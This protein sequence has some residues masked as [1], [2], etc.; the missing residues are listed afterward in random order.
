[1]IIAASGCLADQR[2]AKLLVVKL[3][4]SIAQSQEHSASASPSK[5]PS[6]SKQ[7]ECASAT[8]TEWPIGHVTGA[9][10]NLQPTTQ[11]VAE[12]VSSHTTGAIQ[13]S[14]IQQ[15]AILQFVVHNDW[16]CD[17]TWAVCSCKQAGRVTWQPSG[18]IH[19]A[20][21][22]CSV[23]HGAY[24]HVLYQQ[25]RH[26]MNCK[27]GELLQSLL[28]SR[29]Q[30]HSQETQRTPERCKVWG[31]ATSSFIFYLQDTRRYIYRIKCAGH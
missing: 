28:T 1:M 8:A 27:G 6:P 20:T 4:D 2:S 17:A 5:R 25:Q 21:Q 13:Q 31:A 30:C 3:E 22:D 15:F 29:L 23:R 26:S 19:L 14:T 12:C 10:H 16:V 24:Q 9:I 18:V 7:L 11:Q